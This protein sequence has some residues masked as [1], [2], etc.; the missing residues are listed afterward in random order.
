MFNERP[1][2]K[3]KSSTIRLGGVDIREV[4]R[5]DWLS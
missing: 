4:S 3:S 1:F 2:Y 5:R